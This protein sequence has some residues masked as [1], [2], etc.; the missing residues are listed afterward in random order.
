MDPV[1]STFRPLTASQRRIGKYF[2][3]VAAVLLV[4]ILA[5]IDHGPL[6]FR[7]HELLRHRGRRLPAV[8]FP[9]RRAYPV[10]DRLD[11]PFLDRRGAVPGPGDQRRRKPRARD[12]LVDLLFWVTL[13]VVA[14]ALIGNYL[15]IMGY[16]GEGWF[17]F[18]NQGL[19][20][21]QLGR[22]W[23][24]GFFAGLVDLEPAGVPRAVADA[25]RRW[26]R[27]RRQFWTGPHPAR[28]SDLGL[29][30]SI[31]RCSMCSA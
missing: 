29:H 12:L 18:G 24:I 6:L 14:G 31:S 16:I 1:L 15:G 8:Q 20:Y 7:P 11:R 13:F 5:G 9:A 17:W 22:F 3:V 28:A 30:R 26:R 2:L 19:S 23:Q 25:R 21:I 10:A 27:R 4:Q